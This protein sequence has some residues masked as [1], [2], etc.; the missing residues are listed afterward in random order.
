MGVRGGGEAC[1]G[2]KGRCGWVGDSGDVWWVG[3]RGGGV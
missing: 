2:V 1:V 3:V